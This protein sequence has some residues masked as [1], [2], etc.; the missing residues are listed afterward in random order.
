VQSTTPAVAARCRPDYLDAG[1]P[2]ELGVERR[3]VGSVSDAEAARAELEAIIRAWIVW[4]D[5][6]QRDV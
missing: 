3:W 5:S 2:A 4:R 6:A 1:E